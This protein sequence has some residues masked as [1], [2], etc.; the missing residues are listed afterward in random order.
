[1]MEFDGTRR[2][3]GTGVA[4]VL[5]LRQFPTSEQTM[6]GCFHGLVPTLQS[7]LFPP[8]TLDS[9]CN[10]AWTPNAQQASAQPES[11]PS[12]NFSALFTLLQWPKDSSSSMFTPSTCK[13]SENNLPNPR[14]QSIVGNERGGKAPIGKGDYKFQELQT[15]T[16]HFMK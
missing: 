7:S 6:N 4:I 9:T 12:L 13:L 3:M 14:R 11:C 2:Y 10:A 8:L 1:M 16:F 5:W 15:V